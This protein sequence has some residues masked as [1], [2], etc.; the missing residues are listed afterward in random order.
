MAIC[1]ES[2]MAPPPPE[3]VGLRI[4]DAVMGEGLLPLGLSC[5][6]SWEHLL[7]SWVLQDA[8]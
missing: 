8:G 5:L 3:L 1:H 6:V 4:S 7:G 2:R